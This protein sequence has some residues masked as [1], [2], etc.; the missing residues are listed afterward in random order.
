MGEGLA[1][2]LLRAG[3]QPGRLTLTVRR[4]EHA[5][6]LRDRLPCA[7]TRDNAAAAATAD[8]LVLATKPQDA[9]GALAE[10]AAS[11]ADRRVLVIS[12][13]AGLPTAGIEGRLG[14][15]AAVVRV[16]SNTAL[17]VGEA[18]SVLSAGRTVD[19]DDLAVAEDIMGTVGRVMVLPEEQQDVASALSGHG[20]AYVYFL[21]EV[22]THAGVFAGV[23]HQVARELLVQTIAGAAVQLR[24][25][26]RHPVELR[27]A[28][29]SRG[30]ATIHAF[31]EIERHNVRDAIFDA[32]VS[33]ARRGGELAS[34]VSLPR[35]RP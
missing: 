17:T 2:G 32:V 34:F 16:M 30:G 23:S 22:L 24:E 27:E 26:G 13:A 33:A 12:L 21:A 28:I 14:A 10:V 18:M 9:G 29:M 15:S 19:E 25:G 3:Y 11:V 7:V 5:A 1:A 8:V 31:R 20:A 6:R 4:E 35:P